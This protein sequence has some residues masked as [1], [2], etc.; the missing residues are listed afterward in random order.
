MKKKD[1]FGTFT[2]EATQDLEYFNGYIFDCASDFGL[3]NP[4][5][6]YSFY[7]GYELIY[8]YSSK[9]DVNKK[10]NKNW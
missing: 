8:I 4:H 3:P 5:H 7:P 9:F 6:L 1:E 2:F 10:P